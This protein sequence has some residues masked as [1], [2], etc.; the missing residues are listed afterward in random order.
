[1]QAATHPLRVLSR[2]PA[3]A[4]RDVPINQSITLRFSAPLDADLVDSSD[5]RLFSGVLEIPGTLRVDHLERT[6]TFSPVEKLRTD[7]EH[8]VF[9]RRGIRAHDGT[10]L[11]DAQTFDFVTGTRTAPETPPRPTVP[12]AE[13]QQFFDSR[14]STCHSGAYPPAGVD[15]SSPSAARRSLVGVASDTG[16]LRVVVGDHARSYLIRKIEGLF[17]FS[18]LAMPPEGPA[19]EAEELRLV[20]DWIDGGLTDSSLD[21]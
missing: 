17:G 21:N 10:F 2:V 20:A 8:R 9:L 18:G 15:L 1:M 7:L 19:L 16:A 13:I 11:P 14:C 4:D 5:L 12:D 6:L 3:P